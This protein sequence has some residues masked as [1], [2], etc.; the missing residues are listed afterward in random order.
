MKMREKHFH[1]VGQSVSSFQDQEYRGRHPEWRS[2]YPDP[3]QLVSLVSV[4]VLILGTGE[5]I[6][7]IRGDEASRTEDVENTECVCFAA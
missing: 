2:D 5:M 1:Q 4:L 7:M 6:V 3:H